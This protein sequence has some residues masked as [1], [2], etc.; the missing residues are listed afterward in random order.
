M[1]ALDIL[2]F[3]VSYVENGF[4]I[5]GDVILMDNARWQISM[6]Y[7]PTLTE[8]LEAH[9]IQLRFL[10]KYSPELSPIELVFSV[11]KN[12]IR[13]KIL[14][15]PMMLQVL[16]ELADFGFQDHMAKYIHC[17]AQ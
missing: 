15:V 11:V 4:L 10:P 1:A 3:F 5:E 17:W 12:K 9:K 7:L 6:E 16:F 14:T 8:M 13:N 2:D